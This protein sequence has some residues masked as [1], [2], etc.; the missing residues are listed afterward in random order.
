M[1]QPESALEHIAHERLQALSANPYPGRGIIIGRSADAQQYVQ[2]YWI[3]GRSENSRN[4]MFVEE[5]GRLRTR[6]LDPARVENPE[7]VIYTAMD[8]LGDYH[9][10][11]NGDQTDTIMEALRAGKDYREALRV[12]RQEPDTPHHT[13]RI[14]GG[15]Q[16][17]NGR[18]WL[19]ILKAHPSDA[20]KT[21]RAFWEYEVVAPGYGWCIHTYAG[22][23]SPLPSFTGEPYP[24]PLQADPEELARALWSYLHP[25]NRVALAVKT[26]T[27][28]VGQS[29]LSIVNARD[30]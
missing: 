24:L 17:G 5:Q 7:L 1:S 19:A 4:R 25:D 22:D 16:A 20:A 26:I 28:G 10:L 23:G 13:P 3:M 6:P 12:R 27:P 14:A 29:R 9:V 30:A 8:V 2:V 15:L 11:S 21:I 18:A